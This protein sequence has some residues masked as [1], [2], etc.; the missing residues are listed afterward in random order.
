[1]S[2]KISNKD[3]TMQYNCYIVSDVGVRLLDK[4]KVHRTIFSFMIED[5]KEL[6]KFTDQ[7]ENIK[8][9]EIF[10]KNDCSKKQQLVIVTFNNGGKSQIS[11]DNFIKYTDI[12]LNTVS[13]PLEKNFGPVID[14]KFLSKYSLVSDHDI[15]LAYKDW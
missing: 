1:M 14:D 6:I 3:L 5:H 2:A 12:P 10:I 7:Y 9:F 13:K 11:V 8:T 4:G 15:I